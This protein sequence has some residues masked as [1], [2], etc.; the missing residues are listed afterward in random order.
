MVRRMIAHHNRI[1][2][3]MKTRLR[4]LLLSS[5]GA[6]A[7]GLAAL[8]L[9]GARPATAEEFT[10]EQ[11]EQI[12]HD[13]IMAH[14]EVILEAVQAMQARQDAE[15]AAR[16]AENLVQLREEVVGGPTTMVAGNP[17]GD[18]TLV[19]FFDYRC[20]YC[21]R[22]APDVMA[23]I[24]ADAGVRFAM[25]EFPILGEESVYAARA[26]LA[27]AK[28]DMYWE[29]HLALIDFR[30][31]FDEDYELAQALGINGT[32]AFIVGDTIVPGAISLDALQDLIDQARQG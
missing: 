26:A 7:F 4:L 18:V 6:A 23:L 14:P 16:A 15:A 27:A 25:K 2:L 5:L 22:V 3:P 1:D 11:I 30:G 24:D 29:M 12:V 9:A 32:P 10:T 8:G 31:T 19:E 17:D 21:R 28:Q 13:Y 20:T